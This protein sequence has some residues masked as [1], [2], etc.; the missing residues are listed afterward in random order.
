MR[1]AK[2]LLR[3]ASLVLIESTIMTTALHAAPTT[4]PAPTAT[5][6]PENPDLTA[7]REQAKRDVAAGKLSF[8]SILPEAFFLM[9]DSAGSKDVYKFDYFAALLDDRYGIK[10]SRIIVI[11]GRDADARFAQGYDQVAIPAI[12]AK[13]GRGV[14]DKIWRE[15]GKTKDAKRAEYLQKR[16][17][18]ATQPSTRPAVDQ[19][20]NPRK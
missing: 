13:F 8:K 1:S 4:R 16:K 14:L 19:N 10:A 2:N 9:E 12:E 20:S 18:A 3:F 5:T 11:P 15:A 6:Q 17:A 7:G